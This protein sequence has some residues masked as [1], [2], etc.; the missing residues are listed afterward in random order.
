MTDYTCTYYKFRHYEVRVFCKSNGDDGI[1]VL[2]DILKILYPS[3]WESLL[4]DKIDFV[5]SKLASNTIQ[6]IETGRTIELYLA[7]SDEAMEF[8]LYCDDAKDE[9]LY[10][11]LGSWL[12]NKVCSAIEKGIA[13]VGDTFSRFESIDHYATKAINEG[14]YDKYISLEE[15]LEL[16]YK[17]ETAWLRKLFVEMYKTTFG[18]GYLLMAEHRA[19]KNNG[20]NIYPYKSFGLIKPEIDELLSAK[21]IKY[22][23]NF[24]D[25]LEKII[26]SASSSKGWKKILSSD[27]EKVRELITIKSYDQIIE[28]I[29]GTT[30]SSS[31][32]QYILLRYFVEFVKSQRSE[33]K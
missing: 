5:R 13:H 27:A 14:N 15:W 31:P 3:E 9:D 4:E 6:E 32:N 8:W 23:E 2:E 1:I 24:K 25:K 28:Q 26:E 10:E 22:I 33:R 12:E 20:L 16:E 17:I 30:Q 21:N 11:E 7:H 19:Q 29:W 18:G